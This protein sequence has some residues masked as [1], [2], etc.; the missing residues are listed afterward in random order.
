MNRTHRASY[1]AKHPQIVYTLNDSN[2]RRSRPLRRSV[3]NLLRFSC[4][5][6]PQSYESYTSCIVHSQTPSNRIHPQRQQP[7]TEQAIETQR[8]QPFEVQ[9][10]QCTTEHAR[11]AE[12]KVTRMLQSPWPD[13]L[14]GKINSF[15]IRS[16]VCARRLLGLICQGQDRAENVLREL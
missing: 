15:H 2:L 11:H 10:P 3:S 5:S 1:T 12:D 6:V 14:E 13:D 4:R 7:S 16:G 8:E 9:L